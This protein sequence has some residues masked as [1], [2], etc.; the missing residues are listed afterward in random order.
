MK[1]PQNSHVAN[2]CLDELTK[3]DNV[4]RSG[5]IAKRAKEAVVRYVPCVKVVTENDPEKYEAYC[6]RQLL[7]Y[8]PFRAVEDLTVDFDGNA[9]SAWK[10]WSSQLS[11]GLADR[12][13]LVEAVQ[14]GEGHEQT[15]ADEADRASV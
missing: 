1:R 7:K 9:T 3:Q 15:S 2:M 12:I 8:K 5:G 4:N 13:R 6:Y 14:Q 10:D 11:S